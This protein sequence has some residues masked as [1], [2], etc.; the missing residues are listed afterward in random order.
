[1]DIDLFKHIAE[2]APGFISVAVADFLDG[3][4]ETNDKG[5]QRYFIYAGSTWLSVR[6][7]NYYFSLST[8]GIVA[9]SLVTGFV[10]AVLWHFF[11]K[12]WCQQLSSFAHEKLHQNETIF[13]PW[14]LE[15]FVNDGKP[16]Y[17]AV[18]KNG[19]LITEGHL[20]R[21]KNSEYAI[22]V[23]QDLEWQEYYAQAPHGERCIVYL[24]KD[25]YIKEYYLL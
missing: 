8:E 21:V 16:H 23:E 20:V 19:Q 7:L 15:T 2:I 11:I 17:V 12:R 18:F 13:E 6:L 10:L 25:T 9:L 4:T 5:F 24:D 1:M 22:C 14:L 3:N